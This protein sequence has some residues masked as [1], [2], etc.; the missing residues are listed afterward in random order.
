MGLFSS[1]CAKT[2]LPVLASVGWGR[3]APRLTHIVVVPPHGDPYEAVYDGYGLGG[4]GCDFDQLKLV[5]ASDYQGERYA[6]LGPSEP[7]PNQGYFHAPE[8][9]AALIACPGFASHDAYEEA[10]FEFE[11]GLDALDAELL[12][13]HQLP[14]GPKS[15][16]IGQVLARLQSNEPV[17]AAHLEGV[18]PEQALVGLLGRLREIAAPFMAQRAQR[19]SELAVQTVQKYQVRSTP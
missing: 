19:L 9:I 16:R 2:H 5:L 11:Q 1:T 7:E 13:Q 3:E 15:Y 8:F 17:E 6:D 12:E 18:A 10:L 4:D 14:A